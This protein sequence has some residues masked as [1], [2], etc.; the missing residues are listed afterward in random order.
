MKSV[1]DMI[2]LQSVIVYKN[3]Q[4]CFYFIVG[5]ECSSILLFQYRSSDNYGELK[6][7]KQVNIQS[8][9]KK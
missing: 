4:N 2:P 1:T 9:N 3:S 6:A 7:M 8:M 5:S